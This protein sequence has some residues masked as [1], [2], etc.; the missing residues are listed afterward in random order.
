MS[1]MVASIHE[2]NLYYIELCNKFL[3]EPQYV[4]D[5]ND[6]K[7]VDCYGKHA[8]SLQMRYQVDK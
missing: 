2:D 4:R 3:E 1:D 7:V 5:L 6:C 8:Q